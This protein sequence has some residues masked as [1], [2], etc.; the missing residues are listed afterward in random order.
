MRYQ[1]AQ[2]TPNATK[3]NTL[4]LFE[5]RTMHGQPFLQLKSI[6]NAF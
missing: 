5:I 6:E 3:P 4:V 1:I 2:G